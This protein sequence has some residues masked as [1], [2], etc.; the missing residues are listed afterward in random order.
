MN[1]KLQNN[2]TFNIQDAGFNIGVN[3]RITKR[4]KETR[5]NI[6]GTTRS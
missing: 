4:D 5:T 3:V 1:K 2:D 6:N